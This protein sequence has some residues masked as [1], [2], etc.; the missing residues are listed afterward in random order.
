MG[1]NRCRNEN[2]WL[3]QWYLH[4]VK[5]IFTPQK[6][7]VSSLYTFESVAVELIII[8]RNSDSIKETL[9]QEYLE[10]IQSP[11]I[12]E[13]MGDYN[14]FLALI[15]SVKI[16]HE[17]S[18]RNNKYSIDIHILKVL[19]YNVFFLNFCSPDFRQLFFALNIGFQLQ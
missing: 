5:S 10:N 6:T 11:R 18:L 16:R 8:E 4:N 17:F 1:C 14:A 3:L 9:I 19:A 2:M 7:K 12:M 15:A 13:Y